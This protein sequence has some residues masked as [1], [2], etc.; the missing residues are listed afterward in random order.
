VAEASNSWFCYMVRC[1]DGSLYVGIAND[2]AE[3]IKR[4]NWGVGPNYTAKRRPVELIW[5][6]CCGGS[7]AARRRE[8]EVKSWSRAKKL[9]LVQ[10]VRQKTQNPRSGSG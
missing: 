8:K 1:K 3:R 2:V 4:H 7:E 10:P 9:R 5:Y 6:E